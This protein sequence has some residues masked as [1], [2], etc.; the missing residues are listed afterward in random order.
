VQQVTDILGS[1]IP[2][3]ELLDELRR[4][5]ASQSCVWIGFE[6]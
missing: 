4:T 6:A 3:A 2:G 5:A 1:L